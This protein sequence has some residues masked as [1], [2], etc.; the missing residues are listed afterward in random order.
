M[1]TVAHVMVGD[2]EWG[3]REGGWVAGVTLYYSTFARACGCVQVL[4]WT[5]AIVLRHACDP[6]KIGLVHIHYLVLDLPSGRMI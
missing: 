2:V 4:S 5:G 6:S 3:Q 1:Q